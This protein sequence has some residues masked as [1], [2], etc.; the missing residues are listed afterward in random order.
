MTAI[1]IDYPL[2]RGTLGGLF[3]TVFPPSLYDATSVGFI[4]S[5]PRLVFDPANTVVPLRPYVPTVDFG[6]QATEVSRATGWGARALGRALSVS[7]PTAGALLSGAGGHDPD[8][9]MRLNSL[10][11]IVARIH[12]VAGY[13]QS[14]TDRAFKTVHGSATESALDQF[15]AGNTAGAFLAALD[16]LRPPDAGLLVGNS[17]ARVGVATIS[18]VDEE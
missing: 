9:L 16:V 15:R 13:S 6:V 7:H 14:E 4:R 12:A 11:S 10:Y 17:P 18:L 8:L 3:R 2:I 5:A 1:G